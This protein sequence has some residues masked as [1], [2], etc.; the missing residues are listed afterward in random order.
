M[1]FGRGYSCFGG[2]ERFGG[3]ISPFHIGFGI[4]IAFFIIFAIYKFTKKKDNQSD[5]VIEI[6]KMKYVTGEINEEEYINRKNIL[7]K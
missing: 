3:F 6:L 2:A 4:I 5:E 7:K 1:M